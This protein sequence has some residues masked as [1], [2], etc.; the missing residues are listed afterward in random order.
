MTGPSRLPGDI[1]PQGIQTRVQRG[2]NALQRYLG[3]GIRGK[4]VQRMVH[5]QATQLDRL[6][7]DHFDLGGRTLDKRQWIH[8]CGDERGRQAG[9]SRFRVPAGR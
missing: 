8:L 9:G 2:V 5:Q 3:V 7:A 4:E 6:R 1:Q